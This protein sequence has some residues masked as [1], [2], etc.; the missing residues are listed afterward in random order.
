VAGMVPLELHAEIVGALD[1]SH[2]IIITIHDHITHSL[3]YIT[4]NIEQSLGY[5]PNE[6]IGSSRLYRLDNSKIIY[7]Q[8]KFGKFLEMEK[9]FTTTLPQGNILSMERIISTST[10]SSDEN[11]T[12]MMIINSTGSILWSNENMNI[13]FGQSSLI[14]FG[15]LTSPC[16]SHLLILAQADHFLIAL[17]SKKISKQ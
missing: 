17:K 8:N 2:D 5:H 10:F 1:Q 11:H 7:R 3:Q 6:L 14:S 9:I 4:A 13:S 15:N 12:P 16:L